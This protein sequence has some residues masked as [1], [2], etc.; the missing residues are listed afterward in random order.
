MKTDHSQK[1]LLV[2]RNPYMSNPIIYNPS[3]GRNRYFENNNYLSENIDEN[4]DARKKP[5]ALQSATNNNNNNENELDEKYSLAIKSQ[6]SER[7]EKESNNS[8][9]AELIKKRQQHVE[10]KLSLI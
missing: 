5:Y 3:N 7:L 4:E 1:T 6:K 8:N 2:T 9:Y 10:H